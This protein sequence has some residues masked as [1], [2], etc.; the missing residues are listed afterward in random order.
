M[1]ALTVIL[2]PARSTVFQCRQPSWFDSAIKSAYAWI[3][4]K[5]NRYQLAVLSFF[6]V[7]TLYW[8]YIFLTKE[9]VSFHNYFFSFLF[10]LIPLLGG[11]VGM[12][13]S[14]IWG[15]L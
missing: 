3:R 1:S 14:R 8:A 5:S 7:L 6:T 13:S 4:M 10:G 9:I 15:W 2:W 12:I 11:L